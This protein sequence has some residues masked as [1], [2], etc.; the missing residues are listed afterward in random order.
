MRSLFI[1]LVALVAVMAG[2]AW[3]SGSD[4]CKS[5]DDCD[6]EAGLFCD[7]SDAEESTGCGNDEPEGV[8]AERSEVTED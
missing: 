5:D 2:P 3:G 6:T 7:S 8:C 4:G 1:G